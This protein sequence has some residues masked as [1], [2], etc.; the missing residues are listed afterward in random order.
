MAA[1]FSLVEM[2]IALAI[3]AVMMVATWL[4]VASIFKTDDDSRVRV[5]LQLESAAALRRISDLL[6]MTGPSGSLTTGWVSGNYPV[7]GLDQAGGGFPA[8]YTF[9]NSTNYQTLPTGASNPITNDA[10]GHLAPST[11]TD[12]Y[13]GASNEIAF[14]LPRPAPW[15]YP[16]PVPS[17]AVENPIDDTGVPVDLNGQ[18]TWGISS[19][20][21]QYYGSGPITGA[22]TALADRQTDVYAIVLVPTTSL[23]RDPLTGLLL[24]GPNQLE[25]REFSTAPNRYLIRRT[26]LAYNVE[27]IAFASVTGSGYYLTGSTSPDFQ[28]ATLGTNQLKVTLWMWKNDMNKKS[29]ASISAF[30][31]KSS[32]VINLRSTGE[33]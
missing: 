25:L 24:A 8:P 33:N 31:V 12:G 15:Y 7:F 4:V 10:V 13:Y 19:S 14:Q 22:G 2:M 11:D 23:Q 30:R 29:S 9:V 20:L 5:E 3:S 6:K 18:V 27:R 26:V 1:G 28:D 17:G 32:I 21:Y 16:N